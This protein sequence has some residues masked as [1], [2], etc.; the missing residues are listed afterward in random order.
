MKIG[1]FDSG[2]GG[3]IIT[4]SL[5]QRLPQY[6]YLYLGDTARVPYGNRSQEA[7]YEFTRQAVEY[8]FKHNCGLVII[9]CNTASAEALRR[10]QQE[11]L[12]LH[13]PKRRVIGVLIPAAEAAVEASLAQKIGVLATRGTVASSAFN[14]ELHKLAPKAE[15]K[16]RAAPLLVPL[17]ENDGLK[18]AGP[19]LDEYLTPL[20]GIDTLILGCTHYPFLKDQIRQ[21]VGEGVK[22]ISQDEILPP[23][24]DDYLHRHPEI[25]STLSKNQER[26]FQVTDLTDDTT[27]LSRDLFGGA[28]S[29]HQVSL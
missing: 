27:R 28:V 16:L 24:L 1:I 29:L 22:V 14:R 26:T 17:V 19:I 7:I 13:Y 9:A 11:Y 6:D 12:P 18:W 23:K 10:I 8:L 4:H 25:E 20:K 3:L 15:V 2:L 5:I 21:K